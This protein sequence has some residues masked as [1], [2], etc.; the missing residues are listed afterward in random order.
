MEK[1]V[2]APIGVTSPLSTRPARLLHTLT[3]SMP[4][5]RVGG[6]SAAS[7]PHVAVPAAGGGGA[8]DIC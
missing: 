3:S 5:R 7:S 8:A 4:Q 6:P 2:D 1:G